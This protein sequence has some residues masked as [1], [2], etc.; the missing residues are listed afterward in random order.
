MKNSDLRNENWKSLVFE[1]EPWIKN[2]NNAR[3]IQN[4]AYWYYALKVSLDASVS[5]ISSLIWNIGLSG[6]SRL[7]FAFRY[8]GKRGMLNL[9]S[10]KVRS[11]E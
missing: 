6:F 4:A 3:P 7:F 2:H 9:F 8:L 1:K 10:G 11:A 5:G